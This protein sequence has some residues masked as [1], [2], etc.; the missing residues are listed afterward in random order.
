M[1]TRAMIWLGFVGLGVALALLLGGCAPAPVRIQGSGVEVP[2][3]IGYLV[4][5]AE[6]PTEPMCGA[7]K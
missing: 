7:R 5:C 6:N 2:A 3:P 4:W 1:I